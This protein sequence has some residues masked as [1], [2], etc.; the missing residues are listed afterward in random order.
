MVFIAN[1]A[2]LFAFAAVD[3]PRV[4]LV[5]GL[6]ARRALACAPRNFP[7]ANDAGNT[8]KEL[9]ISPP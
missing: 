8:V 4:A 7:I 9:Q 1:L 6:A 2:A 3:P 5:A